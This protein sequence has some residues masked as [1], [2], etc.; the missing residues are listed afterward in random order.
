MNAT[1]YHLEARAPF[2]FGLRGVGI[3]ETAAHAPSDTLFSALCYAIRQQFSAA[4]LEEFVS[5]YAAGQ[6]AL[7]LSSGFPYVLARR[8]D[9]VEGWQPPE[10]LDPTQVVRF[11]PRP[12]EPPPGVSDDA[13]QRKRVKR[14][15]WLSEGIFRTWVDGGDLGGH[16]SENNL[17]QGGQAWLTAREREAVAGWRDE[18]TDAIRFWAVGEVP[19]V[20]VDRRASTSQIYQAGRVWFQPGCGLWLLAQWREDWRTRGELALRVLG[21][22]GIGGERSA[23]HGQFRVHGPHSLSPLPDPTPGKRFVT[24]SLYYPARDELAEV[25]GGDGVRYRLQVR[26]GWMASPDASQSS[27][28]KTV[29]GSGLRRKAVRMVGEGS[30]LRWPEGKTFVGTLADVTPE[31]FTAH[32][33]WRYGLVFPVGYHALEKEAGDE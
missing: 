26:R 32:T 7:I 14:I 17:V 20:T 25:L 6:P 33:V 4:K 10:L 11:F 31:A 3:E 2:H 22:A 5:T 9:Q 15:A 27:D 28:G 1:A 16:F 30:L 21:D 12:L 13:E 24:L 23:G 29:R 18:E 19:R 8:E